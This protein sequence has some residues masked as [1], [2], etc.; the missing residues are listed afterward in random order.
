MS[1][2]LPQKKK[3]THPSIQRNQNYSVKQTV[4]MLPFGVIENVLLPTSEVVSI[5][6]LERSGIIEDSS[7]FLLKPTCII[8]FELV[9]NRFSIKCS[10]SFIGNH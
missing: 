6:L 8:R 9:S 2:L 7:S 4:I 5:L 10:I 1:A 3:Q